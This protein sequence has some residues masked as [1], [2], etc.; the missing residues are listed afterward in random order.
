MF[1]FEGQV[2]F[3][4]VLQTAVHCQIVSYQSRVSFTVAQHIYVGFFLLRH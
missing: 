2:F 3:F 1:A 4:L